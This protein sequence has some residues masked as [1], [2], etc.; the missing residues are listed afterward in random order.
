MFELPL[1]RPA[2]MGVINVTPDSF[3]DGG[4]HFGPSD[5]VRSALRMMEH[6]ADLIDVGGESTRPG[7]LEVPLEEE[8]RRVIP[9]VRELRK[10]D[11]PISADTRKPA[12]A[13]AALEEGAVVVNDVTGF[14]NPEMIEVCAAADCTICIMHML[15]TPET[16]Q[17][18]PSYKDVVQD[19][20][21][22]LLAQASACE[23][24]GTRPSRI[25][26]DPGIGFGK[27]V[28]HNLTL[29]RHLP[30]FV[31]AGYPVLIGVSRKSFIGKIL[32]G[33][34]APLPVSERVEGT[35]A[36]QVLAQAAGARVIRT[37]DVL[38][39][40]RAI[41]LAASVLAGA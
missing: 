2:L 27:T 6:G 24:R 28:Q 15:G 38:Q 7:A 1:G 34:A 20:K 25:W 5:A 22:W 23:A 26:L 9:V 12:V 37:H 16:M 8:L 19:V 17:A 33:D 21:T 31:E 40:R 32:G 39:A 30:D 35:L 3:S 13:R 4:V 11:V 41:D 10:H 36:V 18:N 29:L 14:R